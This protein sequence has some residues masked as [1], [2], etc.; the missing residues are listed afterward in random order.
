MMMMF[1]TV[2]VSLTSHSNALEVSDFLSG[3][4]K[5]KTPFLPITGICHH[6]FC[7]T[8]IKDNPF[9]STGILLFKTNFKSHIEVFA[10]V[11]ALSQW[12]RFLYFKTQ[13]SIEVKSLSIILEAHKNTTYVNLLRQ[14]GIRIL[15]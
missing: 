4:K 15:D 5:Y 11:L 6:I 1:S 14:C 2:K 9:H 10:W 8:G 7:E 13:F 12:A 3:Y